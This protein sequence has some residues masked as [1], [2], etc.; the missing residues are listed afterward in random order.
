M[1]ARDVVERLRLRRN[2][3]RLRIF[4]HLHPV[5]DRAQQA[6]RIG[7]LARSF[8][9]QPLH[10]DQGLDGIQRRG[11]AHRSVSSAVDHLLDLDEE[12]DLADPAP[13]TLQIKTRGD[14]RIL[15]EMIADARG[16]LPNFVDHSE[17]ER[18]PPNERLDGVEKALPEGDI[19]GRRASTDE[20]RALPRQSGE[21]I[22]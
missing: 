10:C 17:I 11:R 12:L 2:E 9:V 13:T 4:D 5:L 18:A 22:M 19:A 1:Q 21:L 7:E 15:R 6:I 14:L 3:V 20:C 8:P 16:N